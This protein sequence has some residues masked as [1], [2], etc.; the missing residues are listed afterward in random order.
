M[1][2]KED[3]EAV[4]ESQPL[5]NSNDRDRIIQKGNDPS[6]I[7]Q[8]GN[9]ISLTIQQRN[10]GNWTIQNNDCIEKGQG[11]KEGKPTNYTCNNNNDGMPSEIKGITT[12]R[13]SPSLSDRKLIQERP[14]RCYK[15]VKIQ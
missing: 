10:E 4:T 12:R 15:G 14:V 11:G 6:S 13:I 2:A 1:P 3:V 9:E 7:P 8:E 5:K